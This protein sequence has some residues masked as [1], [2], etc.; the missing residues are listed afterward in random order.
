VKTAA[1]FVTIALFIFF[2]KNTAVAQGI[3][4]PIDH[5]GIVWAEVIE[6]MLEV[7]GIVETE[8]PPPWEEIISYTPIPCAKVELIDK[9]DCA[10]PE[11][12]GTRSLFFYYLFQVRFDEFCDTCVCFFKKNEPQRGEACICNDWLKLDARAWI[13]DICDNE[14][15]MRLPG[16][17]QFLDKEERIVFHAELRNDKCR[18]QFPN[19]VVGVVNGCSQIDQ[20]FELHRI[21]DPDSCRAEYYYVGENVRFLPTAGPAAT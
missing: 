14:V 7:R 17:M 8:E 18:A 5:N 20:R 1:G 21:P 6:N 15:N 10:N 9:W 19:T 16:H 2:A 3:A 4:F 12:H 11:R 13:T